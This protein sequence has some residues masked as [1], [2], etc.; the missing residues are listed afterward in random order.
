MASTTRASSEERGE[1][2]S[3]DTSW[4]SEVM[5]SWRTIGWIGLGV[6]ALGATLGSIGLGLTLDAQ[7]DL[8]RVCM[9]NGA[10][11]R[12]AGEELDAYERWRLVAASGAAVTVAGAAM[13][14]VGFVLSSNES[15]SPKIT[16]ERSGKVVIAPWL[17]LSQAGLGG[18]FF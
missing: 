10:C 7:A 14:I 5:P 12:S 2:R 9:S 3:T 15:S 4:A 13:A 6:G 1:R 11:P 16:H 17:G 18:T 8:D